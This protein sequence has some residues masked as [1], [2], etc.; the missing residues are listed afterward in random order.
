MLGHRVSELLKS[1]DVD[2]IVITHGTDTI[3]E[4]AY[5]L[6]LTLESTKPV[7][8]VGSMRPG[9]ALSADGP[10]NLYNAVVVA[11]SKEA[12]GM[13]TLIVMNDEIHSARDVAKTNSLKVDT[14][15]SPYGPLG[16]VVESKAYFYRAPVR[17]HTTKTEFNIDEIKSLPEVAVVYAHGNM[18]R[19][20]YDAFVQ[21]GAKAI[22]H[23]GTGNGSIADYLEGAVKEARTKGVFIVRSTRT[24]SGMVVRNGEEDDDKNDY[25]VVGDQSPHKARILMALALLKTTDTKELQDIF[26]R[27]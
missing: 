7:V 8:L 23:A 9:T 6:N 25:I 27:Y 24:G 2:G 5:F 1:N 17:P 12:A 15:K 11:S 21:A 19:V 22:I 26:W 13:G 16:M 10:L 14:F 20:P 3:E 4:S 18:N